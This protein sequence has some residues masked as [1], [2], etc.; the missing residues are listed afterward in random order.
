MFLASQ[1]LI[2]ISGHPNPIK[3]DS[4]HLSRIA[5]NRDSPMS[6]KYYPSSSKYQPFGFYKK[7]HSQHY[8]QRENEDVETGLCNILVRLNLEEK[9]FG[10]R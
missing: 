6:G 9:H 10:N 2:Y 8:I 7:V 3:L 1:S 5:Y 4:A